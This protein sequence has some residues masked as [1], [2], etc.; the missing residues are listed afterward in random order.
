MQRLICRL[1]PQSTSSQPAPFL[2]G[3]KAYI[4]CDN[5][6]ILK[7]ES[8]FS[9]HL[10]FH[11]YISNNFCCLIG[12]TGALTVR[13]TAGERFSTKSQW[14]NAASVQTL[15]DLNSL[16]RRRYCT[17]FICFGITKTPILLLPWN[18]VLKSES[19]SKLKWPTL[20]W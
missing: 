17:S 1:C 5:L 6:S 12:N 4:L 16:S 7:E 3:P 13:K 10:I 2:S 9:F 18:C 20:Y 19:Q 8:F 11:N 14:S 15:T